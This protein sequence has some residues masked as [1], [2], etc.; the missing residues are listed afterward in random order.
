[1]AGISDKAIKTNY[2][3]NKYRFN[4]GSELQNK[5]FSDGTGLEMYETNLREL[6]PQL[7]RWW[8]E[9]SKPD[10]AQSLYASM[11]NNPIL[12]ND[13]RGDT[14]WDQQGK[15]VTYTTNKD[16]TL[17]WSKNASA[18]WKRIGN[19]LAKN[20]E[21][22]TVLNSMANAEWGITM[23]VSEENDPTDLGRTTPHY[24]WDDKTQSVKITSADVVVYEGSIK[25]MQGQTDAGLQHIGPRGE[26]Y[27]Q[28]FKLGDEESA[29][30]ATA[31]HEGSHASEYDNINA[32]ARNTHLGERNNTE[33]IP[34]RNELNYLQQAIDL[35]VLYIMINIL[36]AQN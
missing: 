19:D 16:G 3:E 13:P 26:A 24:T 30:A 34:Q 6:D 33:T 15:A 22:M 10:Y 12:R 2:A 17:S 28:L 5:E 25:E 11:G 21:G 31:A 1:M 8:Q 14:L 32:K 27:D 20:E 7:G 23:R 36:G 29:L 9:D 4:K 18:D 35:D